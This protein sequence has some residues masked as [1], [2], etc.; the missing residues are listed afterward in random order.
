MEFKAS[1]QNEHKNNSASDDLNRDGNIIEFKA[2]LHNEGRPTMVFNK[3]TKNNIKFKAKLH[4][5]RRPTTV[6]LNE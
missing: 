1:L 6:P 3:C 2:T 4:N 5:M